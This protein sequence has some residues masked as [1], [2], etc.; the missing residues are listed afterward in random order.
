MT[1]E[2]AELQPVTN[3]SSKHGLILSP[4]GFLVSYYLGHTRV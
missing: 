2:A 3:A 4:G 1:L